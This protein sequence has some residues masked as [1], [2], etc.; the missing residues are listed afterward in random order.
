MI[1]HGGKTSEDGI[2]EKF[3]DDLWVFNMDKLNWI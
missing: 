3:L 2:K 1:I